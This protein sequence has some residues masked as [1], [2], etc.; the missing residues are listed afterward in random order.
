VPAVL[1][2]W[3]SSCSCDERR[4]NAGGALH[5]QAIVEQGGLERKVAFYVSGREDKVY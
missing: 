4:N 3:D 1:L 2:N 5:R